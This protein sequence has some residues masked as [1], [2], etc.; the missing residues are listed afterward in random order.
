MPSPPGYKRDYKEEEKTAKARG[1][2]DKG[3]TSGDAERHRAR[4]EMMKLGAVKKGQDVDHIKPL[5]EGGAATDKKNLRPR[6]VHANRSYKRT[7][8]G[9]IKKP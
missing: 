2:T 5:S 3:S 8:S 4:R 1:E 6:S 9:A 7:A